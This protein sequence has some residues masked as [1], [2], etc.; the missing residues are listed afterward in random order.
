[1]SLW[2]YFVELTAGGSCVALTVVS[3]VF[4]TGFAGNGVPVTV[5]QVC[6]NF[7]STGMPSSPS[8][9]G[10]GSPNLTPPPPPPPVGMTP[11]RGLHHQPS[12]HRSVGITSPQPV[13][14]NFL[15]RS[16]KFPH[17]HPSVFDCCG[18]SGILGLFHLRNLP[19]GVIISSQPLA[20]SKSLS[21]MTVIS[22]E[23]GR[24]GQLKGQI[25]FG[26]FL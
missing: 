7:S 4:G 8:S 23:K 25:R 3:P 10:F 1:M 22:K 6:S 13:G 20:H 12:I 15:M 14:V 26:H 5:P 2:S 11:T 9:S 16:F 24:M 21:L 17:F 19:T 18:P